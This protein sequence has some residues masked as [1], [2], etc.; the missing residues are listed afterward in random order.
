VDMGVEVDIILIR[1]VKI[2]IK[3]FRS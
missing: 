1:E 3:F 2:V